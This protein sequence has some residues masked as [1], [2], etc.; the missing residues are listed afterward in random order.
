M[1][2]HPGRG[3]PVGT[4]LAGNRWDLIAPPARHDRSV[5]VVLT[6]FEQPAQLARTL[7][8]LRRQTQPPVQ[9]VVADDGS[10]T[11]PSVPDG[12]EVVR[13]EDRGFRAAAARNLGARRAHGE[14][15]VFLDADTTPEPAFVEH[16]TA[17]PAC[18]PELLA[19]GRRRHADLDGLSAE[20]WVEQHGPGRALPEPRWLADAYRRSHDLRHADEGSYRFVISAAMAC[21]RWWF[22][23]LGGFDET[24][25][26]YGGEDWELAHRSW[27]GGG[28]VAH[29]PGAVTWHDGPDASARPR[30]E[31]RD[32]ED[33]ATLET[34]AIAARVGAPGAAYRGL[35]VGPVDLVVTAAADLGRRELSISLDGL[36]AAAP[37]SRVQLDPRRASWFAEDPRITTDDVLAAGTARLHLH[38]REALVGHPGA[39]AGVLRGLDG[40][41]DVATLDVTSQGRDIAALHDLRLHRRAARWGRNDLLVRSSLASAL[42]PAGGVT[43][44]AWVGGWA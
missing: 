8:A 16:L 30:P 10:R 13:Q 4:P 26:A 44:Q 21:S 3:P 25:T 17:L 28:L 39:W 35:L 22:E 9:V 18:L 43:L 23:E 12:V 11:P 27:L 7:L 37:R 14:L 42:A 36:L 32:G 41:A 33:P 2:E 5:T 31:P 19:V 38:L 6:H 40:Q 20:H 29:V 1:G 24:F 34:A 15:L